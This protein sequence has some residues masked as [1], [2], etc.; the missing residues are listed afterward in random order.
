MK[1]LWGFLPSYSPIGQF[2][3]GNSLQLSVNY[4]PY[5]LKKDLNGSPYDNIRIKFQIYQ[6]ETTFLLIFASV[7]LWVPSKDSTVLWGSKQRRLT[8]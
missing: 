4:F 7:L 2:G 3:L 6:K 1:E 5:L 8:S